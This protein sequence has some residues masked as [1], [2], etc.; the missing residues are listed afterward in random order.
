MKIS[1]EQFKKCY[2]YFSL[3]FLLCTIFFFNL[4]YLMIPNLRNDDLKFVYFHLKDNVLINNLL[5]SWIFQVGLIVYRTNRAI[6][7]KYQVLYKITSYEYMLPH[8]CYILQDM[9]FFFYI[10]HFYIYI[11][12]L[13]KV[14][15]YRLMLLRLHCTLCY[16]SGHVIPFFFSWSHNFKIV[17]TNFRMIIN[18]HNK[19]QLV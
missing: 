11:Y 7:T 8:K 19:S 15:A 18:L 13:L 12:I 10:T 17:F 6:C 9:F 4:Y 5:K 1:I 14:E 2:L 3:K 16:I